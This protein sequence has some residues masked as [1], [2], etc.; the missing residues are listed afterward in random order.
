MK[1]EDKFL[2]F[3]TLMAILALYVAVGHLAA[4]AIDK[5][6]FPG[7]EVVA[8]EEKTKQIW[9]MPDLDRTFRQISNAVDRAEKYGYT[10]FILVNPKDSR[11]YTDLECEIRELEELS[12]D[13]ETE[14]KNSW[15]PMRA[16]NE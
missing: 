2:T 10:V 1:A 16:K 14:I 3:I 13:L 15:E 11:E 8:V 5:N 4:N 6:I 7:F 12:R 9:L